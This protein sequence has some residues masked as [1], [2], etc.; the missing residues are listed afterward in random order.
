MGGTRRPVQTSEV[1]QVAGIVIRPEG[2]GIVIEMT[3]DAAPGS[4]RA[5]SERH[6]EKE[7]PRWKTTSWKSLSA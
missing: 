4:P 1:L 3:V 5:F 6:R 7:A 2:K